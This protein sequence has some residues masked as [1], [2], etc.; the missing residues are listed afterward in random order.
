M[1]ATRGDCGQRRKA[2]G[3]GGRE[4]ARRHDNEDL[5]VLCRA[6]FLERQ[7]A[8]ALRRV[9]VAGRQ[10]SAQPAI[11]SAVGRMAD[12]LEPVAGD[13]TRADHEL[14]V[15]LLRRHMGAH[16][17][18]ERVAVGDADR[19][20]AEGRRLLHNLLG[21]RGAA[22]EREVRRGDELGEAAHGK[23]PCTNHRGVVRLR[24]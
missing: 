12:R 13:Q 21:M 19:S 22:Q 3:E 2:F 10:Q 9:L 20:E 5:P 8:F 24:L 11:G 16:D 23:T 17:A 18:G 1:N 15:N 7:M 6:K 14:D 4:Y